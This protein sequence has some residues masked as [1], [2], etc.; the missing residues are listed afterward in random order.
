MDA[1]LEAKLWMVPKQFDLIDDG[2]VVI[3]SDSG[4]MDL[5]DVAE[6]ARVVFSLNQF[7]QFPA[8]FFIDRIAA[9]HPEDPFATGVAKRFVPRR[10]EIIAP[11]KVE[12][13]RPKCSRRAMLG[14]SMCAHHNNLQ[15]ELNLARHKDLAYE[16]MSST[17]RKCLACFFHAPKRQDVRD[18]QQSTPNCQS[19]FH[20]ADVFEHTV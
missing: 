15:Y 2:Q 3:P 17:S 11:G 4:A 10:R 6:R 9:I 8:I 5:H 16:P 7:A 12:D 13:P 1:E 18:G 14:L 20:L 19:S